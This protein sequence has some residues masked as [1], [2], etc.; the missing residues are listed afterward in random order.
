MRNLFAIVLFTYTLA[1]CT[2]TTGQKPCGTDDK[3]VACAPA[4][5]DD[6]K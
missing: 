3:S 4:K 2:G 1:A 6:K 5:S